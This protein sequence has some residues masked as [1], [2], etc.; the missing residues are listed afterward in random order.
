MVFLFQHHKI[1]NGV[2]ERRVN[3]T[4]PDSAARLNYW[5]VVSVEPMYP[6]GIVD[7]DDSFLESD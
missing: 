6:L 5:V 4:T 3:S 2:I 1:Q 7:F